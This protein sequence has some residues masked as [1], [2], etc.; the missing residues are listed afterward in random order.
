L[1]NIS[2]VPWIGSVPVLGALF[3]ST[4]YQ[5]HQ[6]DLVVIVTPHLVAP[7]TPGQPLESPLDQRVQGNDIDTFLLGQPEVYKKKKDYVSAGERL[8]GPYG[9]IM[10]AQAEVK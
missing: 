6:T 3:R 5:Q 2:Q 10:P 9:F 7:G 1:T 4:Q 8:Q